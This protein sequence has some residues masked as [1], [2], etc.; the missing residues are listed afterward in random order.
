MV[1]YNCR[2]CGYSAE[3]STK[4]E[5]CPNC[6]RPKAMSREESAEELLDNVRE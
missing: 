4:P 1:R 2:Y 3:R 6:G 5:I